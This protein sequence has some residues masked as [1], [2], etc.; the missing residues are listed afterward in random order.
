MPPLKGST[1]KKYPLVDFCSFLEAHYS[2]TSAGAYVSRVRAVLSALGCPSDDLSVLKDYVTDEDRVRQHF[3][4]IGWGTAAQATTAWRVFATWLDTQGIQATTLESVRQPSGRRGFSPS[5]RPDPR[6]VGLQDK[7][8]PLPPK[9]IAATWCLVDKVDAFVKTACP[10]TSSTL[11]SLTWRKI[12]FGRFG[13]PF[14]LEPSDRVTFEIPMCVYRYEPPYEEWKVLWTWARGDRLAPLPEEPVLVGVPGSGQMIDPE[15][16]L[17]VLARGRAGKIPPLLEGTETAQD[18][19][20][21]LIRYTAPPVPPGFPPAPARP[22][23]KNV[24]ELV[25]E[26]RLLR[27]RL[28]ADPPQTIASLGL[29]EPLDEIDPHGGWPEEQES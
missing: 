14:W 22:N 4:E 20:G 21:T 8:I 15:I 1:Y 17:A 25:E 19:G 29:V 12:R 16:L 6:G 13:N 24:F 5:S 3:T 11:L 18:P 23:P 26:A 2:L 9:V 7:P 27:E 10:M 28:A